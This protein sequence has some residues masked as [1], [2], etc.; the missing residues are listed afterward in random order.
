MLLSWLKA[1]SKADSLAR[2]P[3]HPVISRRVSIYHGGTVPQDI[4][5][6]ARLMLPA[7][8]RGSGAASEFKTRWPFGVQRSARRTPIMH[9]RPSSDATWVGIIK[10]ESHFVL[11]NDSCFGMLTKKQ[12]WPCSPFQVLANV[13]R[14]S[15][16]PHP[17][18]TAPAAAD[19][20]EPR[21]LPTVEPTARVG[22]V[23]RGTRV[24]H[25]STPLLHGPAQSR[26]AHVWAVRS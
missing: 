4:S 22:L 9:E 18:S 15:I 14:R 19:L 26:S 7:E 11:V 12:R 5:L 25:V 3:C 1:S 13:T 21:S 2:K 23:G 6:G 20:R 24:Q 10:Q 17:H 16:H 8:P